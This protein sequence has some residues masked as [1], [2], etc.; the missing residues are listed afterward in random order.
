MIDGINYI[1]NLTLAKF[2][3]EYKFMADCMHS[4]DIPLETQTQGV[5]RLS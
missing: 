1:N 5:D 2:M 4:A 3:V